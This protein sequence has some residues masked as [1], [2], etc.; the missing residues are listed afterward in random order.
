MYNNKYILEFSYSYSQNESPENTRYSKSGIKSRKF[1]KRKNDREYQYSNKLESNNTFYND[2][3]NIFSKNAS[4]GIRN[5]NSTKGMLRISNRKIDALNQ[6]ILNNEHDLTLNPNND[7]VY[8]F[9]YFYRML[10]KTTQLDYM[11]AVRLQSS[12]K[13]LYR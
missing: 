8:I 1:F 4:L 7:Y 5:I 13:M 6:S 10:D 2:K 12:Y 9:L 3:V 11:L